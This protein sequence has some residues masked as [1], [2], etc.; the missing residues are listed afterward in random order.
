MRSSLSKLPLALLAV[1]SAIF[2][3]ATPAL[4]NA[5]MCAQ[6]PA[7]L[8]AIAAGAQIDAQKKAIRNIDLGEA[9]CDA[10]NRSEA[11][12]KFSLAA[13]ALGTDIATVMA[14]TTVAAAQ[15]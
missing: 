3:T 11:S 6:A 1:G 13:K 9:L 7:K 12:K 5:E 10:R 2:L 8:R 4:A 14:G 15:Q